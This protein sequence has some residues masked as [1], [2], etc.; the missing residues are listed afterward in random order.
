MVNFSTSRLQLFE[1]P[2][3]NDGFRWFENHRRS[4]SEIQS[5]T[6]E[7]YGANEFW[8]WTGDGDFGSPVAVQFYLHY[9]EQD[10]EML[11]VWWDAYRPM[12]PVELVRQL[13]DDPSRVCVHYYI[14][15]H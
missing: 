14:M 10:E 3:T 4:W 11:G 8:H 9:Q 2:Q 1:G 6:K 5:R 15:E 13:R 12:D 7:K